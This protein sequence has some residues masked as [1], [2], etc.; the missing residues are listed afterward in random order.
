M[1]RERGRGREKRAN[2]G[3]RNSLVENEEHIEFVS[4]QV[5]MADFS[6]MDCLKNLSNI[7][8]S[9]TNMQVLATFSLT[10]TH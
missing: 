10:H 8:P 3:K 1:E 6:Q 2:K 5:K 4:H 7:K 9:H